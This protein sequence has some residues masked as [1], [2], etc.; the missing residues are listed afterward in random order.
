MTSLGGRGGEGRGGEGRGEERRGKRGGYLGFPLSRLFFLPPVLSLLPLSPYPSSSLPVYSP[1]SSLPLSLPP[2]RSPPP[3]PSRRRRGEE[4]EGK[5]FG[6]SFFPPFRLFS[7]PSLLPVIPQP[8]SSPPMSSPPSSLPPSLP[9][10]RSPPSSSFSEKE[11]R[12]RGKR[13]GHVT[14]GKFGSRLFLPSSPP[15]SLCLSPSS[16]PSIPPSFPLSLPSP[17]FT[18]EGSGWGVRKEG[19]RKR[20]GAPQNQNY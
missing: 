17:P 19:G 10:L 9:P 15:F 2:L 6:I 1:P 8:S 16:L 12:R 3:P 7:P 18:V 20:E 11:R 13:Q 5:V 14:R 4:R